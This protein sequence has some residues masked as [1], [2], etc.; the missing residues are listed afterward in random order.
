M[1]H[2]TASQLRE[3]L[4]AAISKVA[5]GGERI[6]LRRNNKNVAA[7]I[8][9]KDYSLLNAL[10]D[11][12]DLEEMKRAMEEPGDKIPWDKVKKEFGL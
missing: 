5:F 4:S 9:M 11:K 6:I 2:I 3:N 7:L 12:L 10:E 1:T 8:S